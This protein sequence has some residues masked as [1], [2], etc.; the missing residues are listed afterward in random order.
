MSTENAQTPAQTSPSGDP[1]ATPPEAVNPAPAGQGDASQPEKA[2]RPDWLPEQFWDADG[3]AIKGADLQTHINELNAFKAEQD[4]KL[5]AVP[6]KP[7]GYELK[8]PADLKFADGEGFEIDPN[9]PMAAFG[10]EIAHMMGADQSAFEQI[11]GRYAQM[12]IAQAKEIQALQAAQMEALGPKAAER[13]GAVKTFLAAKLGPDALAIFEPVLMLKTG[14][15]SMERLMRVASSG[16][17][18][19]FSQGGR[20]GGKVAPSE[21]EYAAMSPAE[22]LVAARK[23]ANGGR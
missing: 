7:D 6:E 22:R 15:E 3:G 9:D 13:Q 23:A 18:A 17:M 5:A 10:R 20:D 16:G 4:S 21:D 11:V 2:A 14:V 12:Q 8:L 1:A 19:G